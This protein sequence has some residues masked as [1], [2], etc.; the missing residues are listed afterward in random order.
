MKE[1][2]K[3]MVDLV[4]AKLGLWGPHL[5]RVCCPKVASQ[6]RDLHVMGLFTRSISS[7]EAHSSPCLCHQA[8]PRSGGNPEPGRTKE[9]PF[10][11]THFWIPFGVVPA[12]FSVWDS[13]RTQ[14]RWVDLIFF[15]DPPILPLKRVP[16]QDTCPSGLGLWSQTL[17]YW[18]W[19][20]A[21]EAFEKSL[22]LTVWPALPSSPS[23]RSGL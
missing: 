19:L 5:H 4:L 3:D 2:G 16:A 11:G 20:W 23:S 8:L 14:F 1:E 21:P 18:G 17:L 10:L 15:W 12:L 22:S 7:P 6:R 13:S 9:P